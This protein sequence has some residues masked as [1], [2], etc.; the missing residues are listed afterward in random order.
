MRTPNALRTHRAHIPMRIPLLSLV[1]TL[2]VAAASLGTSHAQAVISE[3]LS[4]NNSGLRDGDAS[5][6]IEI[7]NPSA[8]TIDPPRFEGSCA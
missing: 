1:A 8:A 3:F 2:A 5:D 7:H 4:A 6:W